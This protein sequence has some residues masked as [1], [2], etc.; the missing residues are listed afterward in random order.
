M[1]DYVP[2]R[3]Q[4]TREHQSNHSQPKTK[5]ITKIRVVD[6]QNGKFNIFL[7]FRLFF[8]DSLSS[9]SI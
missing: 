9:T 4:L 7:F 8:S 5:K 6:I 2:A 1:I 3:L